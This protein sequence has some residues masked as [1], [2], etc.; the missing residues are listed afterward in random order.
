MTIEHTRMM[1]ILL[2]HYYSHDATR[3]LEGGYNLRTLVNA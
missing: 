2:Q 3:D 1:L